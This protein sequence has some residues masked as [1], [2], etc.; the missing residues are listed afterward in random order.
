MRP[1][2]LEMHMFGPYTET[3]T[4]DFSR[5]GEGGVFLIT[6]DTGAGKTTLFDGMVYALYGRVTNDRR[7]GASLRSAHA[8][9]QDSTWVRLTFEHAGQT[10]VIE[11][12]PSYERSLKR[13]EGTTRQE[14]R[15]CLTLPDGKTIENDNQARQAVEEL[16]RLDFE[17]FR[18]VSML[19]QGE[20][21]KFLL[22]KSRDRELIFRKLFNTDSCARLSECL[23]ERA[24]GLE[25]RVAALEQ[26]IALRLGMIDLPAED[27]AAPALRD[28]APSQAA[29]R[30]DLLEQANRRAEEALKESR[31]RLE[32]A[33]EAYARALTE[34][35]RARQENRLFDQLLRQREQLARLESGEDEANRQRE[36]LDAARRAQQA[37]P[38]AALL[39]QLR[40]QC[41]RAQAQK[42]ALEARA[43]QAGQRL[44]LAQKE[45]SQLPALQEELTAIAAR[46]EEYRRILPLYEQR[47]EA[48]R[49][50][51]RARQQA[52]QLA[53]ELAVRKQA[54]A[55]LAER[56]GHC[57]ARLE[58]LSDL[59]ERCRAGQKALADLRAQL[60][61]LARLSALLR[62]RQRAQDSLA[63]LLEQ[64]APLAAQSLAAE[65]VYQQAYASFLREQ[66][67][68]LARSLTPG[69]PCPVCGATEHPSPA[70]LSPRAL[71]QAELEQLK[72]ASEHARARLEQVNAEC[73]RAQ[74]R[75]H[76]LEEAARPLA[77]ALNLSAEAEPVRAAILQKQTLFRRSEETYRALLEQAELKKRLQQALE[78]CRAQQTR[79]QAELEDW[80]GRL[81]AAR[82]EGERALATHQTLCA[83][84][85]SSAPDNLRD[86]QKE[87]EARQGLLTLSI[88]G[89]R[90]A[91]RARE[92]EKTELDGRLHTA[93][94]QLDG[95]TRQRDEAQSAFETS[96]AEQRFDGEQAFRAARM[97]EAAQNALSARLEDFASRLQFA[98][99]ENARLLEETRGKTPV[100][101]ARLEQALSQAQAEQKSQRE[102]VKAQEQ[103]LTLNRQLLE[104]LSALCR[105][106][107]E[108][109]EQYAC[110]LGLSNECSGKSVGRFRISFEQYLQRHYLEAVVEQANVHL[111]RMT[112][113]RYRLI[114]REQLRGLIE[115][116]LE[117]DVYDGFSMRARPVGTLSGGEAF[118]AALALALGLSE[119]VMRE[120]GG[121]RIDTLF[122]DEGFGS[123]DEASLDEAV[124]VL[125]QL[126]E[127]SR[128]VGIVSHVAEL[129][130]RIDRQ[131]V[132][133]A[134]PGEGSQVRLIAE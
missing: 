57:A 20:F 112:D 65:H 24:S 45:S 21:L 59:E 90:Q 121:V 6:G 26:E 72:R 54:L 95:L 113:G 120:S 28:C 127:G 98:R 32:Q 18:Q 108:T 75:I 60:D 82:E 37:Q 13:G 79:L 106:H 81:A 107:A 96:L 56:Q 93:C 22:A 69:A 89:L 88:E 74:E 14:A 39:E 85:P 41:E 23:R 123:L 5:F 91:L 100:D 66:A 63:Q 34:Q 61:T 73:G 105:D 42:V 92:Q 4:V 47:E 15:V 84:L 43:A 7:T 11:R 12:S 86:R 35:E 128:L 109:S 94:E 78:E 16:L 116:A 83:Q 64:Q 1:L 102:A 87:A 67:G 50:L 133:T 17:Q 40:G 71:S 9:P 131:I 8:G 130:E 38:R 119:I 68:L 46:L 55:V 30:L 58:E 134:R 44:S 2:T 10:Y 19:A 117:L 129:R 122:I 132:V 99:R 118:E 31:A 62:D 29:S 52:A 3:T 80:T 51:A 36:R 111:S 77:Q 114:R 125:T 70:H 25:G 49:A 103:R 110:V 53:P 76:T 126:G 115:G 33:D 97:E 48:A 104:R 101:A 27:P 124:G